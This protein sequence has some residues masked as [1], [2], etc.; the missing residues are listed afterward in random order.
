VNHFDCNARA[1]NV[2]REGR[3]PHTPLDQLHGAVP[4]KGPHPLLVMFRQAEMGE[5]KIHR[6]GKV[7]E[8]I[9]QRSVQVKND[10]GFLLEHSAPKCRNLP[11]EFHFHKKTVKAKRRHTQDEHKHDYE[12]HRVF[13]K[14]VIRLA[15]RELPADNR[16][17][18]KR[19]E[20]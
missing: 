9:E 8:G 14:T 17:Y 20:Y 18:E 16:T 5:R 12:L 6:H 19:Q 11:Q 4:D 2:F 15:I 13:A 7:A 3:L 10:Q 1:G